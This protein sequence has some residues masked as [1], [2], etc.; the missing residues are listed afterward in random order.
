MKLILRLIT[1]GLRDC[2]DLLVSLVG[3]DEMYVSEYSDHLEIINS[4]F[5]RHSDNDHFFVLLQFY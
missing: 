4:Q 3:R 2:E 5:Y 1:Q